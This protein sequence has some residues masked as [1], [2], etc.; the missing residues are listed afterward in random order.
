MADL[1]KKLHAEGRRTLAQTFFGEGTY[2][3]KL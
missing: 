1:M 3:F 2:Q